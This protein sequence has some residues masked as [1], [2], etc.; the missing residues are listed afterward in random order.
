MEPLLGC[1]DLVKLRWSRGTGSD[2]ST[3]AEMDEERRWKGGVGVGGSFSSRNQPAQSWEKTVFEW[4][5]EDE[6]SD[7]KVAGLSADLFPTPDSEKKVLAKAHSFL[8]KQR[9][10]K[11][12]QKN[13][14]TSWSF[15]N[16]A[17]TGVPQDVNV[18]RQ[19]EKRDRRREKRK[20]FKDKKKGVFL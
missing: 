4:R 17:T 13:D 1:K 16:Y 15:T 8:Q 5:G 18:L 20:V 14:K 10:E 12:V 11:I 7:A 6:S 19:M 9:P 3:V 2:E